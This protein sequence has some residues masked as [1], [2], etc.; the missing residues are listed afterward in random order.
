MLREVSEGVFVFKGVQSD[1]FHFVCVQALVCVQLF[2]SKAT[3][4]LAVISRDS[5]CA[6]SHTLDNEIRRAEMK[7]L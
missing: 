3:L 7:A 2:P 1:V 6:F 4:Q 5:W